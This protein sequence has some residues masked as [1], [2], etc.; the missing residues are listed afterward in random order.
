MSEQTAP[1]EKTD[2]YY[3]TSID[4]EAPADVIYDY[5][6]DFPRHVEWNH[7]PTEMISL[8]DGPVRVGSQYQTKE[9]GASTASGADKIL[10]PIFISAMKLLFGAGGYTVAE[11]TAL[12]PNSRVAWKARFPSDKRGDLVSM[13]WEIVLQPQDEET[14]VTQH[15][16]IKTPASSPLPSPNA[17][18]LKKNK[19]EVSANLARLKKIVETHMVGQAVQVTGQAA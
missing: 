3:E 7:Q 2:F 19:E 8:T 12:E 14:I 6:A 5:V 15:C 4:I 16:E 10:G 11:I 18:M 17:T 1:S 9:Q 13:N